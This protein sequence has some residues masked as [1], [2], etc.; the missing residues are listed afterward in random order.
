MTTKNVAQND[1]LMNSLARLAAL[2]P[3]TAQ[4]N[5]ETASKTE[6]RERESVPPLP[7]TKK[8]VTSPSPERVLSKA[9]T[10]APTVMIAKE[11]PKR[12]GRPTQKTGDLKADYVK[13]SPAIPRDLKDRMDRA[14]LDL[15]KEENLGILTMEDLVSKA[16]DEFLNRRHT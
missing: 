10:K 9:P 15:R 4:M 14:I 8:T 16:V 13:I 6:P 1:R 5:A 12:M 2:P 11:P 3:V 7:T